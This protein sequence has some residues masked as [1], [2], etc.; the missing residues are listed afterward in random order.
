MLKGGGVT[1]LTRLQLRLRAEGRRRAGSR[2]S[3]V[4][5]GRGGGGLAGCREGAGQRQQDCLLGGVEEEQDEVDAGDGDILLG[6]GDRGC[7][8]YAADRPLPD[9]HVLASD[10]G[11]LAVALSRLPR[12]EDLGQHGEGAAGGGQGPGGA[13]GGREVR[14]AEMR[15]LVREEWVSEERGQAGMEEGRGGQEV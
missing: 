1:R 6:L 2:G 11:A 14:G 5:R 8:L 12:E 4:G 7:G 10:G 9:G 13:G 3:V 15:E